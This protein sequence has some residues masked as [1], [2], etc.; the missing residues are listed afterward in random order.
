MKS[1]KHTF[2]TNLRTARELKD[3]KQH[4]LAKATGLNVSAISHFETGN[5]IPSLPNFVLLVNA[6]N[7]SADYLLG[8]GDR[9]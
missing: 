4:H 3:W 9:T 7:V 2:T 1:L 5:R 6:L 8:T